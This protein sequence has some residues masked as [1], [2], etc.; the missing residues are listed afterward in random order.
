MIFMNETTTLPERIE[1]ATTSQPYTLRFSTITFHVDMSKG[2][3]LEWNNGVSSI[4]LEE[5]DP[6]DHAKAT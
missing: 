6:S 2:E 1:E 3:S 4:A 5:L